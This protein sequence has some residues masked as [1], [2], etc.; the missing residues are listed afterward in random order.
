MAAVIVLQALALIGTGLLVLSL[1]P[2]AAGRPG[3]W[4]VLGVFLVYVLADFR[5]WFQ[6]TRDSWLVLLAVDLLV[7]GL[8]RRPAASGLAWPAGW[9]FFGGLAALINP[10]V[11]FAWGVLSLLAAPWQ[12]SW[13]RLALAGLVA[14]VTVAPWTVRNYLV[15]GRCIPIKSNLAHELYQSQCLTSDGLIDRAT[16]K[17]HPHGLAKRKEYRDLG[18]VDFLDRKYEQV[19]QAV[20]DDPGDFLGRAANRFL[21]ATL[22]YQPWDR[23][24]GAERPWALWASRLLYP[25][26]F[27]ALLALL[28]TS[29][30]DLHQ[31]QW[32]VVGVYL[33]YLLPYIAVSYYDRY[34]M[35]LLG[36]K[37]LL[38]LSAVGRLLGVLRPP[39]I[40]A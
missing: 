24:P 5:C 28:F 36:V 1:A 6:L 34:A 9:G 12:R 18:E 19:R 23:T 29:R 16:F 33:L 27:L 31:A 14:G 4:L 7:A 13:S 35:P 15:F 20:R 21:A 22:W 10:I 25:L 2:D 17:L 3:P 37:V 8:C 11:G 26:P 30:G 38:V 32:V 39:V 40:S